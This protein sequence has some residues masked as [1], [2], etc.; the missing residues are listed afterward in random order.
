MENI[1][2]IQYL[3]EEV[4]YCVTAISKLFFWGLIPSWGKP[5]WSSVSW[6]SVTTN[7]KTSDH[8]VKGHPCLYYLSQVPFCYHSNGPFWTSLTANIVLRHLVLYLISVFEGQSLRDIPSKLLSILIWQILD[9][10]VPWYYI[11]L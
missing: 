6:S 8:L 11:A 2:S 10:G 7:L 3:V 4:F 9:N 5:T 1:E